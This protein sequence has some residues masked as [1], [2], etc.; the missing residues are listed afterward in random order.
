MMAMMTMTMVMMIVMIMMVMTIRMV[1]ISDDAG[2]TLIERPRLPS[3][4]R[5]SLT[6]LY[7]QI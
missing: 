3:S 5:S 1:I 2:D 4:A 7:K 6:S